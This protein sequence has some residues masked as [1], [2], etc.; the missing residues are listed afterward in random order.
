MNPIMPWD[1]LAALGSAVGSMVADGWISAM[2]SFWAAALWLLGLVLGFMDSVLQPDLRPTGPARDVYQ[3]TFALAGA[4]AVTLSLVQTGLA[5][6]RRDGRSFGRL[7]LGTAQFWL[8]LASGLTY[9]ALVVTSASALTRALM[10]T[11]LGV[12]S[13]RDWRLW[14]PFALQDITDMAV[15]TILAILA[16]FVIVAA[17]AFFVILV[18]RDAVLLVMA[19]T[20]P[21]AAAG[22]VAELGH[23]WL[24]KLARWFH[25]AAFTPLVVVLVL[26]IGLKVSAGVAAGQADGIA[27]S[28]GTAFGAV[29]VTI[30]ATISPLALFKLLAF[31]DPGTASGAS[32]RAGWAAIGGLQGLIRGPET[33]GGG[34]SSSA[35]Q[36]APSGT[37]QGEADASS[38]TQGRVSS[39][40]AHLGATTSP[41]PAGA[42][43]AGQGGQPQESWW[44]KARG[45]AADA[46]GAYATI[47]S[48]GAALG[49]DVTNQAGVGHNGYYPDFTGSNP[50]H[51][52]NG[53]VAHQHTNQQQPAPQPTPPAPGPQAPAPWAPAPWPLTPPAPPGPATTAPSDSGGNPS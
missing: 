45:G 27:A 2:L 46:L 53:Q 37:S 3:V 42:G 48:Q 35:S 47:G 34:A 7:L 8:F 18:V 17:V 13:W 22:L 51:H 50:R 14:E 49:A 10:E 24:W 11:L 19:V 28:I 29:V 1:V 20:A 9:A 6:V 23:T 4:L 43:G 36:Q 16:G 15:A 30:I 5:V 41:A 38:H 25:A 39:A 12:T 21:I 40:M 52:Q 44:D 26:G 31:V 33:T 32:A